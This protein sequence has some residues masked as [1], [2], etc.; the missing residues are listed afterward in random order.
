MTKNSESWNY[1][2]RSRGRAL[3]LAWRAK[4]EPLKILEDG[5]PKVRTYARSVLALLPDRLVCR[6]RTG[7]HDADGAVSLFILY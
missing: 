6:L 7:S 5:P 3:L 4:R 1:R 2:V